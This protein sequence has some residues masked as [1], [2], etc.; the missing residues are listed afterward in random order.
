MDQQWWLRLIKTVAYQ[1]LKLEHH[2]KLLSSMNFKNYFS[3]L[4]EKLRHQ[5]I[6]PVQGSLSMGEKVLSLF[7]NMPADLSRSSGLLFLPTN[8][9]K[10]TVSE[11]RP[12]LL[13]CSSPA[14]SFV[15]IARHLSKLHSLTHCCLTV[16]WNHRKQ[17]HPSGI[18]RNYEVKS[19]KTLK[20]MA[21][22]CFVLFLSTSVLYLQ[23]KYIPSD[24]FWVTTIL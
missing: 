17:K 5:K 1:L 14:T 22:F 13:I 19:A 6:N 8:L 7:K 15:A 16:I 18:K 11:E 9:Q 4:L 10:S 2:S 20:G 21:P 3:F 24:L 23:E 12:I